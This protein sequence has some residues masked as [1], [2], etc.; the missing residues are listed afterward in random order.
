MNFLLLLII[1]L[2]WSVPTAWTGPKASKIFNAA[3]FDPCNGYRPLNPVE[4]HKARALSTRILAHCGLRVVQDVLVKLQIPGFAIPQIQ[5]GMC[6]FIN[7]VYGLHSG[8][9]PNNHLELK[10]GTKT[11]DLL[12][13]VDIF[14][15][16]LEK[17]G[18]TQKIRHGSRLFL[19]TPST[20]RKIG[21]ISTTCAFGVDA[22]RPPMDGNSLLY[23]TNYYRS[24]IQLTL[25]HILKS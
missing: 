5:L 6:I 11:D 16:A 2:I 18:Y 19:L 12:R 15:T 9:N 7:V 24:V 22:S 3:P 14:M 8:L 20:A 4:V 1:H 23:A 17:G 10:K 21:L 25:P 13:T